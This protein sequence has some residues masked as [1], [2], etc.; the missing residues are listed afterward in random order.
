MQLFKPFP[1][2]FIDRIELK[3]FNRWGGLVYETNDPDINWD[4]TNLEGKN[5]KDG[6]YFYVCRV[7]ETRVI[8][9]VEQTDLLEGPI[10][11]IR[12]R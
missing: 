7:F 11:I 8:G 2:R 4:G 1:Y 6:V 3:I 10:H 5:L 12:G 9:I